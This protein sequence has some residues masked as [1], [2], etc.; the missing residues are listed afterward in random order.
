MFSTLLLI[1][2]GITIR[3]LVKKNLANFAGCEHRRGLM[4]SGGGVHSTECHSIE[5]YH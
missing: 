1:S 4:G 2:Q 5:L 3:N